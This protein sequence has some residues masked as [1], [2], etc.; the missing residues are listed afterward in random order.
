MSEIE[1]WF[2]EMPK[3]S[4]LEGTELSNASVLN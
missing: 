2:V 1:S 3:T 4:G